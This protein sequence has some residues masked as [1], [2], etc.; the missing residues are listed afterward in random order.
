[1]TVWLVQETWSN[2]ADLSSAS[3]FGPIRNILTIEDNPSTL[4]LKCMSKIRRVLEEDFDRENDYLCY[5]MADPAAL[6]LMGTALAEYDLFPV[7]WLRWE[8]SRDPSGAR[9][10]GSGFYVS[11]WIDV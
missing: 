8:R 6:L 1:M 5:V 3:K 11:G 2:K 9:I 10:K 4:P 7:Q